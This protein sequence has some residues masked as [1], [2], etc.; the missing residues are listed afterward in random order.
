MIEPA[1]NCSFTLTTGDSKQSRIRRLKNGVPQGLVLTLLLLNLYILFLRLYL[2]STISRKFTCA[3]GLALLHSFESWKDSERTLC[4]DMATLSAYLQIW[5]L[6]FNHTKTVSA[7]FHLN[8][9]EA[10]RKLKVHNTIG[11]TVLSNPYLSWGNT[12]QISFVPSP[13]CG[14]SQ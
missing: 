7:A 14:I 8:N 2:P 10:K 6:K 12:G 11:L 9:Q 13:Y 3:N 4:Q 5:K 1:R